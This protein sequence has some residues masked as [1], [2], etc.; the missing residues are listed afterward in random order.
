VRYLFV[1]FRL[2]AW[3]NNEAVIRAEHVKSEAESDPFREK[4]EDH[5]HALQASLP[6]R[7]SEAVDGV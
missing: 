4:E 3:R 2:I 7:L 5:V 6:Y 1:F